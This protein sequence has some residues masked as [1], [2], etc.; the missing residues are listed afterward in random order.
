MDWVLL[1]ARDA[2]VETEAETESETGIETGD[3]G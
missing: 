3:A 2:S 1:R